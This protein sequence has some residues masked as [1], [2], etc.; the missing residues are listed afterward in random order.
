MK[1]QCQLMNNSSLRYEPFDFHHECR[2]MRWDRLSI[3][4]DR[5]A[6][7]QQEMGQCGVASRSAQGFALGVF[8]VKTNAV[9]CGLIGNCDQ[10]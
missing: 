10:L 2:K 4:M 7:E 1:Q 5:I 9:L 8:S 6:E 3:L